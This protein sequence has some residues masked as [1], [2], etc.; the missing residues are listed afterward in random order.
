MD[1]DETAFT[2]RYRRSEVT[3]AVAR[4]LRALARRHLRTELAELAHA[5]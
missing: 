2:W 1:N 3:P 4:L 5:Q